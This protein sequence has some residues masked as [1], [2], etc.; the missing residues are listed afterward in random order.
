MPPLLIRPCVYTTHPRETIDVHNGAMLLA[1]LLTIHSWFRWAVVISTLILGARCASGWIR[2]RRWTSVDA[3]FGRAWVG[4]LDLQVSL[5][6]LLYFT[7]SPMAAAARQNFR[8]A[9]TNDWLRFFGIVHPLSMLT[10]ALVMHAAWTWARRT[11]DASNERFRR[12]GL[13][14]LGALVLV[15]LAIPWPFLP[16]GRPLARM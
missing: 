2:K 6:L 12:L 15:A 5:G 14:V 9:W 16:Y 11:E 1:V 3:A 4:A 13:G 8:S 7:A 10:A